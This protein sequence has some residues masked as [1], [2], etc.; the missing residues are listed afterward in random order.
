MGAE[1]SC[2]VVV[3]ME[4]VVVNY[5]SSPRIAPHRLGQR[6]AAL[7]MSKG[8]VCHRDRGLTLRGVRAAGPCGYALQRQVTTPRV[9]CQMIAPALIHRKPGERIRANRRDARKLAE[10][11]RGGLLTEV[12]PPTNAPNEPRA[13]AT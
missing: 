9:R 2:F 6:D 12:R 5:L 7:S 10:L 11:L 4:F 8:G 3:E 13:A 1:K